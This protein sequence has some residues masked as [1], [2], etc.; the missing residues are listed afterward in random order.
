MKIH[1]QGVALLLTVM[2][3]LLG[4][5]KWASPTI[6]EALGP[7]GAIQATSSPDPVPGSSD[8]LAE[9]PLTSDEITTLQTILD[10]IGFDVGGIDGIKGPKTK[11]AIAKAKNDLK[12]AEGT[13]DRKLF[14]RLVILTAS[15]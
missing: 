8:A 3:V 1:L 12:L 5:A 7:D 4:M 11:A 9:L 2:L 14:E 15:N 10:S 13:S 6:H